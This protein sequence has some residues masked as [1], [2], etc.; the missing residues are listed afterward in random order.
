MLVLSLNKQQPE[1]LS[2]EKHKFTDMTSA[3][4]IPEELPGKV[5]TRNVYLTMSTKNK[6]TKGTMFRCI[7]A[8]R[9]KRYLQLSSWNSSLLAFIFFKTSQ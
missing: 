4:N 2:Y 3:G 8:A 6:I 7:K 1:K 5:A 9:T